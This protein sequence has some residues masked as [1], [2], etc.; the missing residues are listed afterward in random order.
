MKFNRPYT[1]NELSLLVKSTLITSNKNKKIYGINTIAEASNTDITFLLDSSYLKYIKNCK[2]GAILLSE[3]FR[4]SFS[5]NYL[6]TKNPKLDLI[7]FIN[8]CINKELINYNIS[9]KSYV[10]INSCIS[11]N[12][13][14][15]INTI[16][17]D[18]VKIG[19]NSILSPGVIIGNNCIIGKYCKIN[20]GVIFYDN[21]I[22]GDNCNI[23]SNS[24]IG[25]DGFGFVKNK[26]DKWIKI[27]HIGRV[28]I[29]NNVDIGS[30]TSID[31]GMLNDTIIEN[32]VIV[33][34][35]VQIAHNVK[36]GEN[37]AIAGCVG[38]A[39]SSKIG[40]NCMIG[41]GVKISNNLVISDNICITGSSNV[42]KSLDK[43]GIY[44][45]AFV[46]KKNIDW[47]KC[48]SYFYK[49]NKLFIK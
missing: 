13:Y 9:S 36:I 19:C 17:G 21:V 10:G 3:N 31:R 23:N 6:I 37:T 39:G 25:S 32:G 24:T 4:N 46:V 11:D 34:N 18:N 12:V 41:G 35:Q 2:A 20:P 15:G 28:V 8:L 49:L 22:V 38:I 1:L 16:L 44:S 43:I 33:D 30:N 42:T 47:N 40:K 29:G 7:T 14:I 5:D 45:S 27:P 26:Y 48:M